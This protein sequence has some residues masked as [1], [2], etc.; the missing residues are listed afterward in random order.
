MHQPSFYSNKIIWVTGAS[1]GIGEQIALQVAP[2]CAKLVISARREEELKRVKEECPDPK[3]VLI[4]PLDLSDE[5]SVRNAFSQVI[6][7][8]EHIDILFNNGGISQRGY[9]LETPTEVER[10]IFEINFF[11]NVLLTKLVAP[12]MQKR[13][14][15]HI[16]V[17]STLLG[18]WGF[19]TRSAYSASKHAL[20]GYYDSL[21]MEIEKDGVSISIAMPGFI[22]TDISKNAID[23]TG[24]RTGEMD[25]NQAGGISAADCVCK[26][27]DEV[28]SQKTEFAIGGKEIK[29]LVVK[30][31]FPKFF[32][33]ILR[34]RSP[35]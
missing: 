26:L 12:L 9:A 1:S 28:A 18:K 20:H 17:T 4:V 15:G 35:K 34:K 33:K 13:K 21:R 2:F 5:S 3:K 14:S 23:H 25:P 7:E 29:G 16:V 6:T 11:S 24:K 30:R 10:K 22:A 8:V 27:L 19:H 31:F 32:E